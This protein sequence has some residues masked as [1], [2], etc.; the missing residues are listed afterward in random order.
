MFNTMSL[1]FEDRI[2]YFIS[3]PLWTSLLHY[4]EDYKRSWQPITSEG[5][6][7]WT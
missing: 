2:A 1:T 3:N 6:E 5:C 7:I 4:R